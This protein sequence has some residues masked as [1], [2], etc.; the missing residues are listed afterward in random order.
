MAPYCTGLVSSAWAIFM[1]WPS[2]ATLVLIGLVRVVDL[3]ELDHVDAEQ[4]L[5]ALQVLHAVAD[6]LGAGAVVAQHHLV[7][8]V[9][10]GEPGR[11]RVDVEQMVELV[12][13]ELGDLGLLGR[14]LG[15]CLEIRLDLGAGHLDER[16]VTHARGDPGLQRIT[17]VLRP[18]RPLAAWRSAGG[19]RVTTGGRSVRPLESGPPRATVQH[20][21]GGPPPPEVRDPPPG[22]EVTDGRETGAGRSE[23]PLEPAGGI[24]PPTCRLQ[25]GCSAS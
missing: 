18:D 12:L 20:A 15:A 7:A 16:P 5:V 14:D 9:H 22:G 6:V 1:L 3:P 8:D 21:R 10:G 2:W 13:R 23:A 24:E 19:P 11:R 17:S 4:R 25:G